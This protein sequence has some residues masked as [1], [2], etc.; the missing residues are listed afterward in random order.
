MTNEVKRKKPTKI[1]LLITV[2]MLAAAAFVGYRLLFGNIDPE[3]KAAIDR[4]VNQITQDILEEIQQEKPSENATPID[5]QKETREESPEN[6]PDQ[7]LPGEK[8]EAIEKVMS[9]YEKGFGKLQKEGNAIVDRL[10]TAIKSDYMTLKESGAGKT[11]LA[12]LAA[13]YT[14]RVKAMEGGMDS[15]FNLLLT[16]M[17]EDLKSAGMAE[18]EVSSHLQKIKE[19]YNKL[20]EERRSLVLEK[21]KE[22]L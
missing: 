3:E 21:A 12:R 15:S 5:T 17:G 7:V 9:A 19:A 14:N 6:H 13:S 10:I 11:E 2:I 22:Y 1:I 20:K 18:E 16:K 4:E 8:Q